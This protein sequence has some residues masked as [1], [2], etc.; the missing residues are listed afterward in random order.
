[1]SPILVDPEIRADLE[2]E[3]KRQARDVN[4][5]VNESLWEYLEKAREAKLEDEIRA[6]IKMHPRLKRKYLNEW[7]A[8]HEHKLVD[9]EFLSRLQFQTRALRCAKSS[10]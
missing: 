5:I 9:H 2:K 4:E 7:V 6:Y 8:I 1:M 10:P 3:A